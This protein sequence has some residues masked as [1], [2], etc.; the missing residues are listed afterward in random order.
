M[1]E[2]RNRFLSKATDLSYEENDS[3]Y[4]EFMNNI[5]IRDF[6]NKIDI[7]VSASIISIQLQYLTNIEIIN[8]TK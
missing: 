8:R 5:N 3:L 6:K 2:I 4:D 1:I 7:N